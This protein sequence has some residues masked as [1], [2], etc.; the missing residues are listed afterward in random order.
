MRLHLPGILRRTLLACMVGVSSISVSV[1]SGILVCGA[2][3]VLSIPQATAASYEVTL[4]GTAYI[5]D[6]T[7][8]DE[9][10][11]TTTVGWAVAAANNSEHTLHFVAPAAAGEDV[12][13][14][15]Q[16]N[17][18]SAGAL[19]VD[20]GA[21]IAGIGPAGTRQFLLGGSGSYTSTFNRDFALSPSNGLTIRGTHT[22][23]VA[24]GKTLSLTPSGGNLQIQGGTVSIGGGGTVQLGR[25]LTIGEGAGL[26]LQ[27][28]SVLTLADTIANQGTLTLNGT[29]NLSSS[30]RA[31]VAGTANGFCNTVYT[32]ATG[33]AATV[34]A[35]TVWQVDGVAVNGTYADNAVTAASTVYG[36]S[37][38]GS[39]VVA[40]AITGETGFV[41]SGA[42]ATLVLDEVTATL[43]G[44]DAATKLPDGVEI[45]AGEGNGVT[46]ALA[47]GAG[48]FTSDLTRSSGVLNMEVCSG[49]SLYLNEHV[50]NGTLAV[51][52]GGLVLSMVEDGLGTGD[53]AV[54]TLSLTGAQG[55]PAVLQLA[56]G[57]KLETDLELLG[58]AQVSSMF[59]S[60]D[61]HTNGGDITSTGT[62]NVI[63][64][65]VLLGQSVNIAVTGAADSL[66]ISGQLLSSGRVTGDR[67]VT[68]TGEGT[69]SFTYSGAEAENEF[70]GL[71]T[72]DG[73]TLV[74][75]GDATLIRGADVRNGTLRI[76]SGAAVT[77]GATL[78][79][80]AGG[81]LVNE[82]EV[83]RLE[84]LAGFTPQG[85][86]QYLD[87]AGRSGE[88]GYRSGAYL[89]VS[90]AG[91]AGISGVDKVQLGDVQK[92]TTTDAATGSVLLVDTDYSTY[93]V[94]TTLDYDAAALGQVPAFRVVDGATLNTT[95]ADMLGKVT[96]DSDAAGLYFTNEA[97]D[98]LLQFSGVQ[99]SGGLQLTAAAEENAAGLV[100]V[101]SSAFAP[102]Y[103]GNI[104][105]LTGTLLQPDAALA[106]NECSAFG[107][108]YTT[109]TTRT[110]TVQGGAELNNGGKE[111]YYRVVLEEGA[112]LASSVTGMGV[113][114]RNLPVL[115]LAGDATVRTDAEF[116]IVG[117]GHSATQLNLNGHSLTKAG[118]ANFVLRNTTLNAGTLNVQQGKL[119]WHVGTRLP[120]SQL[121]IGGG[122]QVDYADSGANRNLGSL[123]IRSSAT[124]GATGGAID[125]YG[126]AGSLKVTGSTLA[127]ELLT[128]RGEGK[129]VLAGPAIFNAGVTVENGTLEL[130]GPVTLGGGLISVAAGKS[131]TVGSSGSITLA[132]LTGY[133]TASFEIPETNG[134]VETS[135]TCKVLE[136]GEGAVITG[137]TTVNYG[138]VAHALNTTTG[139]VSIAGAKVYYAVENGSTVTVGGSSATTGT[140]DATSFY[141]KKGA[142]L[143]FADELPAGAFAASV[144]GD[145]T[146]GVT[147]A[148]GAHG[149]YVSMPSFTGTLQVNGGNSNIT[150]YELGS[151]ASLQLVAGEH[152]SKD[153]ASTHLD[154]VLPD[155]K[156]SFVFRPKNTFTMHGRVSGQYLDLGTTNTDNGTVVL[157]NAQNDIAHVTLGTAANTARL[158]LAADMGFTTVNALKQESTLKLRDG[159]ALSLGSGAAADVSGVAAL[160]ISD[161]ANTVTVADKAV[162][163]VA[164]LSGAGQLTKG[165]SGVMC[166]T[167]AS[168]AGSIAVQG[169]VLDISGAT[170]AGSLAAGNGAGIKAHRAAS[171]QGALT[172]NPGALLDL[173]TDGTLVMNGQDVFLAPAIQLNVNP[174]LA[175]D[176]DLMTGVGAISGLSFDAYGMAQ[177]AGATVNDRLI[178]AADNLWFV[179]DGT[180]LKLSASAGIRDY[181]WEG[182]DGKWS[183]DKWATV[184]DGTDLT[185][186]ATTDSDMPVNAIFAGTDGGGTDATI[187]LDAAVSVDTLQVKSGEY[188]F[189]AGAADAALQVLGDAVVS[190]GAADWS[191]TGLSVGGNYRQTGGEVLASALQVAGTTTI[192]GG[193][194]GSS[195]ASPLELAGV[196]IG[197][198]A[199][200]N[201]QLVDSTITGQLDTTGALSV[202]GTISIDKSRFDAAHITEATTYSQGVSGFARA[203]YEVQLVKTPGQ[204]T[205]LSGVQWRDKDNVTGSYD[206]A[207]GVLAMSSGSES[208]RYYVN[209]ATTYTSADVRFTNEDGLGATALVLSGGALQLGSSLAASVTEGIVVGNAGENTLL[210]S[211]G[212]VLESSMLHATE[213]NQV[214]LAGAGTYTLAQSDEL[215]LAP[216]VSLGADWRGIIDVGS[217]ASHP[218]LVDAERDLVLAEDLFNAGGAGSTVRLGDTAVRTLTANTGAAG[219]L[220][221]D[222]RLSL[223][224]GTS[225]IT[226]NLTLA[227]DT[228]LG[229]AAHAARLEVTGVLDAGSITLAHAE[230]ALQVGSFARSSLDLQL[231]QTVLY[232]M[233][234]AASAQ[235]LTLITLNGDAAGAPGVTV[236]GADYS[237]GLTDSGS[238]YY[239]TI[240]W[241]GNLL[242]ATGVRNE[243]YVREKLAVTEANARAGATLLNA[244][245]VQLDPQNTPGMEGGNLAALLDSVDA[246][247]VDDE[248]AAAVAGA[249]TAVLGMALS[250]DVERQ[251]RAIRNRT[252]TMGVNQSMVNDN[253]PYL[254]A[255]INA[256]GD[257]REL[258]GDTSAAGYTLSSWG[259][260]VGFDVDIA[261]TFTAGLALTAM[262]GDLSTDGPDTLDADFDTCY[263]SAFAR[264]C[265]SAWTHTFVATIGRM[266]TGYKRTVDHGTGQ[267][268]TEGDSDGLAF[269]LLYEVGRV[270]ALNYESTAC[271]QPVFN[272]AWRHASVGGYTEKGGDAALTVGDQSLDTVTL[273]LGARVQG[274]LAEN[275]FNRTGIL[276]GRLLAKVDLGDRAGS[277]TVGLPG[278]AGAEADVESMEPGAFGLEAGVGITLPV[279]GGDG[280]VF[281]DAAFELRADYTNVNGTVGYRIN[282]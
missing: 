269:G 111:L 236:N 15:V 148:G 55:S 180:T 35:G 23:T 101:T 267:Y 36:V 261:P 251:L 133:T 69:L 257:Y 25:A 185:T 270:F 208:T 16:Y 48:V 264:Y 28:G 150:L 227:G 26:T 210:L 272:V 11:A 213:S 60:G 136:V 13:L 62:G 224:G 265:A 163:N 24:A 78:S 98:R 275:L 103:T 187:A 57:A 89:V 154:I 81:S 279:G 5:H 52:A 252:T 43:A 84:S 88:N 178:T 54:K 14:Q 61:L 164:A 83:L 194:I 214:V 92:T 100:V 229:S 192:S 262:Y 97:G 152:W 234:A 274:E 80:A 45:A 245:F 221:V 179:K 259:G 183:E 91:G 106:L 20:A 137:L 108:R 143:N 7:F 142:T 278:L 155:A 147:Y 223:A 114:S 124:G 260:T 21:D 126:G 250:G 74:L 18:F 268:R 40:S 160:A 254:N 41:V 53:G 4:G 237:A 215:E 131:L 12:T 9:A 162:F 242:Q 249:S 232:D 123:L 50:V 75:G 145:G 199:V 113:G 186:I 96:L 181:Y 238:K 211:N 212:V 51:Q 102:D 233:G 216:G 256:E 193:S 231:D 258:N 107:A 281:M 225:R 87:A 217:V 71:V 246:G 128:K 247:V 2:M 63:S 19:V 276:E 197:H 56:A 110:I 176:I 72:V 125:V 230:S 118:E 32:I 153:A 65:D 159:V 219:R 79:V 95:Q 228:V 226:G 169:G 93:W 117:S 46:V 277:A 105:V 177:A 85:E 209:D 130:N 8:T 157:T 116:G 122:A 34:A 244:A 17:T 39:R 196:S 167:G 174:A 239:L 77:L 172:L 190:G 138:G 201:V 82:G 120:D 49:A 10:D 173:G 204:V 195:G 206:A 115:E 99:G 220:L 243:N 76:G 66:E 170:L 266:D 184:D 188:V 218:R 33:N 263:M 165:G 135:T 139:E 119:T 161:T 22:F 158:E 121:Q 73:G 109:D 149:K 90:A 1:G 175:G 129:L 6:C 70:A 189:T 241:N 144:S 182:G 134:L 207:R 58:H 156:D 37:E 27:A 271:I 203:A 255:W 44:S 67:A 59:A 205:E 132:T 141:V 86:L 235:P 38:A 112:V 31:A 146:V 253:M 198:A 171:V 282:F 166:I 280:S 240:G 94:N 47:T 127:D 200:S 151:G 29:V 64:A 68:K 168:A 248:T 3:A 104:T 202:G 273:G 42:G 30:M 140:A 222:G 191:S